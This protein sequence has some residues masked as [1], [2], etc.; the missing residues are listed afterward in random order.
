MNVHSTAKPL[1]SIHPFAIFASHDAKVGLGPWTYYSYMWPWSHHHC[2][3]ISEMLTL[4]ARIAR[5]SK[6]QE[7]IDILFIALFTIDV[8]TAWLSFAS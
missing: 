7:Q 5:V 2:D 4:L 3:Q 6:L 1:V 8:H